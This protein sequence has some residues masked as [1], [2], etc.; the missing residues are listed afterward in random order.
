MLDRVLEALHYS[1]I[2][3]ALAA[4]LFL[5]LSCSVLG[6]FLVLKRYSLLGDGLAHVCFATTALAFVLA[7]SPLWITLPLVCLTTIGILKLNEKAGLHADAAIGLI[8]SF[9]VAMGV[10]IASLSKGFN[11]DITSTLFGSILTLTQHDIL[12]SA[13]LCLI[14]FLGLFRYYPQ[15]FSLTYDTE[16][17]QISGLPVKKIQ[18]V[19]MILTAVTIA[20]G[21][22]LIGTMLISSLLIFPTV[23][24][25]QLSKS[26][27]QALCL[28]AIIASF[29]MVFGILGSYLFNLPTGAFV[30]LVNGTV[31]LLVFAYNLLRGH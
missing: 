8:S 4:G 11:L 7:V 16:F 12:I 18:A 31:F 1:F 10:C 30:I 22:R 14:L 17:S 20:I 27:K 2:L 26:F 21:I 5:G 19:I 23:T 6:V 29:C 13:G 15:L 25:L 9:S 3:N 24:A 28:S